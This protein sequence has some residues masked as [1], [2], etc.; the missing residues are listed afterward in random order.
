MKHNYIA[1][2]GTIGAGK[3]SLATMMSEHYGANLLLEEFEDNT[4]LPKFYKEPERFAFPLELSFL[5]DRFQQ[6]KQQNLNPDLFGKRTVSDYFLT[7]SLIFASA[8]LAQDEYKLFRDLYDI[9]FQTVP[10]PDL[11]VYLYLPVEKLLENIKKRGRAYEMEIS[12]EY[13]DRVQGQYL[14]SLRKQNEH[15]RTLILD[16]SEVDFVKSANDF[17]SILSIVES[18]LSVG[19]HRM[20]V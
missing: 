20:K 18:E 4:F 15:M 1:I 9:M 2:E 19:L 13:L 14:D 7:K 6:I 11:L 8:N 3:T 17:K 12:Y 16:T 10:K 5:A